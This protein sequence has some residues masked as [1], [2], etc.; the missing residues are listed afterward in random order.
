MQEL[1]PPPPPAGPKDNDGSQ[2]PPPPPMVFYPSQFCVIPAEITEYHS[3]M[4]SS[5][6]GLREIL[7]FVSTVTR[8][9]T[10]PH[11][12]VDEATGLHR[13]DAQDVDNLLPYLCDG[14]PPLRVPYN[15]FEM[16]K[17]F[18]V[19]NIAPERVKYILGPVVTWF[20]LWVY[21]ID[22]DYVT[23]VRPK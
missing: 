19:Y 10:I 2:V 21:C 20:K 1:M 22:Q 15:K 17:V 3:Q 14:I 23:S 7:S 12:K 11:A 6:D 8:L 16:A 4:L 18:K 5:V 9:R 13:I